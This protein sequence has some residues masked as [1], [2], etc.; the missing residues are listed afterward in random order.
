MPNPLQTVGLAVAIAAP[1][2]RPRSGDRRHGACGH[3]SRLDGGPDVPQARP[4]ESAARLRAALEPIQQLRPRWQARRLMSPL[5]S[6]RCRSATAPS[7]DAFLAVSYGFTIF[8][9]LEPL[10]VLTKGNPVGMSS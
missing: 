7:F 2:G 9:I 1:P 5:C 8:S 4:A 3:A 6:P 10:M